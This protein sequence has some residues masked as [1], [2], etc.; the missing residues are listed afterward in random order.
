VEENRV[1]A[2]EAAIVRIMKARTTLSHQKLLSEVMAQ[3]TFFRPE[4][5]D[6]KKRIEAMIDREYLERNP[7]NPTFYNYL[8]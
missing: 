8:A 4:P 6:V 5:R 7:D 2:I 3:L 1:H